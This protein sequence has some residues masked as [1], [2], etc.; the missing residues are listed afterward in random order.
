[1]PIYKEEVA[2][3]DYVYAMESS[4]S[5]SL[6]PSPLLASLPGGAR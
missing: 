4:S 5:A 6:S 1:M 3:E 2:P